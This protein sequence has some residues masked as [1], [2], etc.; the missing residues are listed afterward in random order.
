VDTEL[1]LRSDMQKAA[2]LYSFCSGASSQNRNEHQQ[3]SGYGLGL[4]I[5]QRICEW[6]KASCTL[7]TSKLGGCKFIIEL[8]KDEII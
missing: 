6:H 1:Y 7:S 8:P 3:K 4:A 5:V 2:H